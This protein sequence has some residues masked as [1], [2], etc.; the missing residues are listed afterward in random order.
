MSIETNT[1]DTGVA[2]WGIVEMWE[3]ETPSPYE[4][5]SSSVASDDY[6]NMDFSEKAGH[7]SKV[8]IQVRHTVGTCKCHCWKRQMWSKIRDRGYSCEC[9]FL[10]CGKL[11]H[12]NNVAV[13]GAH[14]DINGETFGIVKACTACNNQHDATMYVYGGSFKRFF[15]QC[16]YRKI[17]GEMAFPFSRKIK[18]LNG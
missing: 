15:C 9:I 13:L 1:N 12:C 6:Y 18:I 14:V 2:S 4:S 3:P 17:Q 5:D 10:V 16:D 7:D 11:E 8:L